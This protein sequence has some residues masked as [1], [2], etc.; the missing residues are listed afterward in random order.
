M[1][2]QCSLCRCSCRAVFADL[3]LRAGAGEFIRRVQNYGQDGKIFPP[4]PE[5]NV[6]SIYPGDLTVYANRQILID[7]I[8]CLFLFSLMRY[9]PPITFICDYLI[10]CIAVCPCHRSQHLFRV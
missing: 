10:H 4:L 3:Y 7:D 9:S 2:W 8:I 6:M 1:H 5:P